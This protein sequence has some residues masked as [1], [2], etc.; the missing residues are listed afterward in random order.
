MQWRVRERFQV[1]PTLGRCV[2]DGPC[3][4][5]EDIDYA[6]VTALEL[7]PGGEEL[8][9]LLGGHIVDMW[10]LPNGALVGRWHLESDAY[11]A[12]CHDGSRLLMTRRHERQ[13]IIEEVLLIST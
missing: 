12:M 1:H 11:T 6:N 7:S 4:L 13:P 9:V 2:R 10:D 3:V 5:S 8:A